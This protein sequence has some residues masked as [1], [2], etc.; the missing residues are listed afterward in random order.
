MSGGGPDD[1]R[2]EQALDLVAGELYEA[3][4]CGAAGV[5]VRADDGQEGMREHGEGDPAGPGC[6]AATAPDPKSAHAGLTLYQVLDTLQN[7]LNPG[8]APAPPANSPC[9]PGPTPHQDRDR[10]DGVLLGRV[11]DVRGAPRIWRLAWR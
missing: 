1:E 11:S 2:T 6:V 3:V 7:T 9:P 8:P 4:R 5:F 10:P